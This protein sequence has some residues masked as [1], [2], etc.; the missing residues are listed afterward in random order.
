MAIKIEA[1]S[2]DFDIRHLAR[3]ISEECV[4]PSAG[5][6]D[7]QDFSRWGKYNDQERS[8]CV[9]LISRIQDMLVSKDLATP[10]SSSRT[11][12]LPSLE[13]WIHFSMIHSGGF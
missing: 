4:W 12:N 2:A 6:A 8:Y 3:Q 10:T 11:K 7:T 13:N 5:G 1:P 9:T